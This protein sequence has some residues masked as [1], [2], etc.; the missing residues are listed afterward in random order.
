MKRIPERNRMKVYHNDSEIV[1]RPELW[2][3]NWVFL[4]T[5]TVF[6]PKD[7]TGGSMK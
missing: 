6:Q 3:M 2:S 4:K 5:R 7:Y 1:L